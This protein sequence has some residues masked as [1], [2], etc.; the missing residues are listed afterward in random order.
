M[1]DMIEVILPEKDWID[2]QEVI[3]DRDETSRT[4]DG[5]R[6][7]KEIDT[8]I[9]KHRV[10]NYG[11]DF[12]S[13]IMDADGITGKQL[14]AMI[15][16][17]HIKMMLNLH[18]LGETHILDCPLSKKAVLRVLELR[19]L[20]YEDVFNLRRLSDLEIIFGERSKL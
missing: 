10:K 5:P 8:A 4:L 1:K 17:G 13:G 14:A 12:R 18:A 3:L 7:Q 15:G 11:G 2:I 9:Y 6:L 20:T 19:G 16:I